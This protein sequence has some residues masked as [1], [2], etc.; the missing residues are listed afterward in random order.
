[1][2]YFTIYR[3]DIN[4][5]RVVLH[6]DLVVVFMSYSMK[7]KN[8]CLM[9]IPQIKKAA[10]FYKNYNIRKKDCGSYYFELI[11]DD[12]NRLGYSVTQIDKKAVDKKIK[13]M[14]VLGIRADYRPQSDNQLNS[15]L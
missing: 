7:S 4:T 6:G 13:E 11:D 12:H 9:L 14:K 8:A 10:Q 2:I 15:V 5:Y 3:E 1:M